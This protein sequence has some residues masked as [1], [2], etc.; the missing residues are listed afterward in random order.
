MFRNG[1]QDAKLTISSIGNFAMNTGLDVTGAITS[2]S[3][4]RS[5]GLSSS[6]N[7]TYTGIQGE[8]LL[9]ATIGTPSF[10]NFTEIG[11]T[12]WGALGT[13]QTTGDLV[14]NTMPTSS[15]TFNGTERL[16]IVRTSGNVGIGTASPG[17]KLDIA[18]NLIFHTDNT[19]DIGASGATRPRTGYY[20]TSVYA[21][22]R[23]GIG[24]TNTTYALDVT[25]T[26]NISTS[27]QSPKFIVTTSVFWSSG[28]GSPEGVLTANI[29]S[30]YSRTDGGANTTLYVKES[31][32]GNTGWV[33]K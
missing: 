23:M 20:G 19:Y 9:A 27:A 16:R 7:S 4:F 15:T 2:T 12:Y 3:S 25:G 29:G 32:T 30:L 17:D 26:A 10:I 33:A 11:Q 6:S 28:T 13:E 18:G 1:I 24:N 14:Y 5:P 8:L 21:G 31:G 22:T